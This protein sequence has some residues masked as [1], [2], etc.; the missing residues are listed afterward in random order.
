MKKNPRERVVRAWA[1][2]F[3]RPAGEIWIT[4]N[5]V[6]PPPCNHQGQLDIYNTRKQA[7]ANKSVLDKIIRVEIRPIKTKGGGK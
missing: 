6:C 4:K 7:M 3:E 5:C 1:V 2:Y